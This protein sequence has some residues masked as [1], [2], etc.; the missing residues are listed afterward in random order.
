MGTVFGDFWSVIDAWR[1]WPG[2]T[3]IT[4][5]TNQYK[6]MNFW[7]QMWDVNVTLKWAKESYY[8]EGV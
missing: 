3:K 8:V 2:N 5:I 1:P 6:A 4:G 7:C